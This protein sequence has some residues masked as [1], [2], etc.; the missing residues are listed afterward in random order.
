MKIIP[1]KSCHWYKRDG[2]PCFQV[3][4]KSGDGFKDVTLREARELNLVPS[5]TTIL[6][7]IAKPELEA[8]KQE[9]C[10]LAALTLPR[11]ENEPLEAFAKRVV[12]DSQEQ[13][14]V[15]AGFGRAIHKQIEL[16]L[17]ANH[18]LPIVPEVEPFMVHWRNWFRAEVE[19]V[20]ATEKCVVN[21]EQGYA[22]TLDLHCKLKGLGSAVVDFKTQNLKPGKP[23]AFYDEWLYQLAAYAKCVNADVV[24]PK[25]VSVV[26]NSKEP[27]PV[28]C[29]QWDDA[30][31]GWQLFNAAFD[32][33]KY[34]KGFD[35]SIQ[36]E[37]NHEPL[38]TP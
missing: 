2:S 27:G 34:Q 31:E 15:A 11:Q 33:W 13:A 22:G 6:R 29:H 21:L 38:H 26:I 36:P 32:L 30:Q 18:V 4:K 20:Y 10:I 23:P 7:I 5:V 28:F 19:E 35:P 25:L 8:W 12:E 3:P 16:E 17:N 37:N 9:Q 24:W 1:E 14:G